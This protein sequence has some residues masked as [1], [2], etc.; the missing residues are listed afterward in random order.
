M[1]KTGKDWVEWATE[2][3]ENVEQ[4][5]EKKTIRLETLKAELISPTAI[6]YDVDKVQTSVVGDKLATKYAEVAELNKEI[7]EDMENLF[8]FKARTAK[9]LHKYVP[10][11]ALAY[12]LEMRH[13]YGM[14]VS[15]LAAEQGVTEICIKKRFSKAYKLLN[16][17]FI[18]EKYRKKCEKVDNIPQKSVIC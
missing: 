7:I 18:L 8:K 3:I 10:N 9:Q 2:H 15:E 14:T 17:I 6:R 13:L 4:Q 5:I 16:S 12:C 11:I 1:I